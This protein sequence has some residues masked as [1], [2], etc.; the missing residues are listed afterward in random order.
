MVE[1]SVHRLEYNETVQRNCV[2]D[3]SD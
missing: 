2:V 1:K 3:R